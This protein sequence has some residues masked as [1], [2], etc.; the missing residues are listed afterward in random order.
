MPL[1]IIQHHINDWLTS[2][3][4]TSNIDFA[5]YNSVFYNIANYIKLLLNLIDSSIQTTFIL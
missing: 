5:K 1:I 2:K 3:D 4:N